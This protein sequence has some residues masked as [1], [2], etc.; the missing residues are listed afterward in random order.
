MRSAIIKTAA[1]A[2]ASLLLLFASCA[3]SP[4]AKPEP[5]PE[6][7]AAQTQI[8]APEASP[9]P[10]VVPE[11]PAPL[12]AKPPEEPRF[13][14][15]A[16]TAEVKTATFVD[17]RTLIEQLNNIIRH[18]DYD[19]WTSHL[20]A[21]YIA[22]YSD[23]AILAKYSEY[24]VIKRSGIKLRTLKDYFINVVYPSRQDDKVDDIEF[25]GENLIKAIV[26]SPKGDRN[27]LYMLE[28]HGDAWKIGI[29]R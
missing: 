23:P 19:A 24:P 17:V 3:S 16:V 15:T 14:P 13:D 21:E 8:P 4:A 29:G 2:V 11:E 25:V 22:F 27:I 26:V 9:E 1:L 6:P 5:L 18:Q 12:P 7:P 10:V 28:K 20:T